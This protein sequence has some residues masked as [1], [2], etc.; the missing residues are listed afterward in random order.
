MLKRFIAL[1]MSFVLVYSLGVQQIVFAVGEIEDQ[2]QLVEEVVEIN[3]VESQETDEI[4]E[5]VLEDNDDSLIAPPQENMQDV[6]AGITD[7]AIENVD[8]SAPFGP[9]RSFESIDN[10]DENVQIDDNVL[11]DSQD[12]FT[13]VESADSDIDDLVTDDSD[14]EE[15]VVPQDR[16]EVESDE[17]SEVLDEELVV[18]DSFQENPVQEIIEYLIGDVDEVEVGNCDNFEEDIAVDDQEIATEEDDILDADDGDDTGIIPEGDDQFSFTNTVEIVETHLVPEVQSIRDRIDRKRGVQVSLD[19]VNTSDV[20]LQVPPLSLDTVVLQ[21]QQS[22]N[23]QAVAAQ[24]TLSS[25][26]PNGSVSLGANSVFLAAFDVTDVGNAGLDFS[27]IQMSVSSGPGA[28]SLPQNARATFQNLRLEMMDNGNRVVVSDIETIDNSGRI[29]F[30]QLSGRFVIGTGEMKTLFLAGD[31][32]SSGVLSGATPYQ[33]QLD[34]NTLSATNGVGTPIPTVDLLSANVVGREITVGAASSATATISV[35]STQPT[36]S[37]YIAQ[38]QTNTLA[39]DAFRFEMGSF[40]ADSILKDFDLQIAALQDVSRSI[41]SVKMF[42]DG[43]FVADSSLVDV[44]GVHFRDVDFKFVN[45]VQSTVLFQVV[46]EQVG[47]GGAIAGDQFHFF[48]DENSFTVAKGGSLVSLSGLELN[49]N[50]SRIDGTLFSPP[51]PIPTF[52]T[53]IIQQSIPEFIPG[54]PLS[55]PILASGN[56]EVF[57]FRILARGI[58]NVEIGDGI[59]ESLLVFEMNQ[60]PGMSVTGCDIRDG[61]GN[62]VAVQSAPFNDHPFLSGTY[63]SQAIQ[64]SFTDAYVHFSEDTF[65]PT[66]KIISNGGFYRVFCDV[67]VP[68]AVVNPVLR[69]SISDSNL[70]GLVDNSGSLLDNAA[71]IPG[72]PLIGT[73]LQGLVNPPSTNPFISLELDAFASG[74]TSIGFKDVVLAQWNFNNQSNESVEARNWRVRLFNT[75]G[76]NVST[77]FNQ[78]LFS[79]MRLAVLDANGRP[80]SNMFPFINLNFGP[81]S[82]SSPIAD[83]QKGLSGFSI[84]L[85]YQGSFLFAAG[86]AYTIGFVADL[87]R[88]ISPSQ[89][90]VILEPLVRTSQPTNLLFDSMGNPIDASSFSTPQIPLVSEVQNIQIEIMDV[91]KSLLLSNSTYELGDKRVDI[92]AFDFSVDAGRDLEIRSFDFEVAPG[93]FGLGSSIPPTERTFKN[94]YIEV[95]DGNGSR[96]SLLA[97]PFSSPFSSIVGGR[98][99][100]DFD[101]SPLLPLIIP[102]GTTRTVFISADIDVM[103]EPFGFNPYSF[104]LGGGVNVYDPI[105]DLSYIVPGATSQEISITAG[106]MSFVVNGDNTVDD[107]NVMQSE[108]TGYAPASGQLFVEIN[109]GVRRYFVPL[110]SSNLV[111]GPFVVSMGDAFQ[112]LADG[113]VEVNLSYY[114]MNAPPE[115]ITLMVQKNTPN[116]TFSILQS[117]T[118]I[119]L[120]SHNIVNLSNVST[121]TLFAST[122]VIGDVFFALFPDGLGGL[123]PT[124]PVLLSDGRYLGSVGPFQFDNLDFDIPSI[125]DGKYDLQVAFYE[126]V[127]QIETIQMI[128]LVK[129]TIINAPIAVALNNQVTVTAS[130]ENDVSIDFEVDE[131][132]S[133]TYD[134]TDGVNMLRDTVML[135]STGAQSISGIDVSSLDNGTLT[136]AVRLTDLAGNTSSDVIDDELKNVLVSTSGGGSSVAR[137]R[138]GAKRA[139]IGKPRKVVDMNVASVQ[140]QNE[141]D[142]VSPD[143]EKNEEFFFPREEDQ[144]KN[145]LD[146]F[147]DLFSEKGSEMIASDMSQDD[148]AAVEVAYLRDKGVVKGKAGTDAFNADEPIDL[149]Q[150]LHIALQ[151]AGVEIPEKASRQVFDSLDMNE[152]YAP[153]IEKAYEMKILSDDAPGS[154]VAWRLINRAEALKIAYMALGIE[155]PK[156]D[157]SFSD[158]DENIDMWFSSYLEDAYKRELVELDR[159]GRR[160]LA[161]PDKNITR[162]EFVQLIVRLSQT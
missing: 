159:Q 123:N 80:V 46:P 126:P 76:S 78:Q 15:C 82:V 127:V 4:V 153:T 67:V 10:N 39:Y 117:P 81:F 121:S 152:W 132:G 151:T 43:N 89:S 65:L 90:V 66:M 86:E 131:L 141:K 139:S 27:R 51:G 34:A 95:D 32:H 128:S 122:D 120:N 60:T 118:S 44:N 112:Q 125:P 21:Q 158:I 143:D 83:Q 70:I 7:A 48:L 11:L 92:A 54:G 93:S 77:Q 69:F 28:A 19:P 104:Q 13:D 156:M 16:E 84:D 107:S 119:V 154:F 142:V 20:L 14:E 35:N 2:Q 137:G 146:Q 129:D 100:F 115:F 161:H 97:D 40:G 55:S 29:F 71:L 148:F 6:D 108:I 106:I 63:P 72:L 31:V 105:S 113:V 75:D 96:A 160:M 135:S 45:N 17:S 33:F 79:N 56:Q 8:N 157:S 59:M 12:E 98:L 9:E 99:T 52:D 64:D 5:E 133:L 42:I 109:D 102:D 140:E 23:A 149:A 138:V 58:G 134:I 53:F 38:D 50:T 1:G 147:F 49:P 116:S 36:S 22:F 25:S 68:S 150:A 30:G 114:P 155:V 37:R 61:G 87:G 41:R 110:Q 85:M 103:G 26:V 24:F 47:A 101:T 73:A 62:V 3:V 18:D 162:A 145:F 91:E 136:L 57:S 124:G 144:P 74:N 130:N 111:P 88:D 94:I